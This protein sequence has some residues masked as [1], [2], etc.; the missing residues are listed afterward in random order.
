MKPKLQRLF[1]ALA[2]LT[3]VHQA[4]AQ[5]V[6]AAGTT[7]QGIDVYNGDGTIN[8]TN[9]KAS[10]ITFAYVEATDGNSYTDPEFATYWTGMK[11]AG[12]IRGAYLFF[13]PDIPGVDQ[14]N[15]FVNVMGTLQPGDL[16]PVVDV[17][18]TDSESAANI[19]TNL[20]ECINELQALTGRVPI[21]YTYT[22]FFADY[23]GGS[24]N[25]SAY[26]LWIA[27]YGITCPTLPA[28]W[29]NWVFWQYSTTGTVS[30]I[31]TPS[32]VD[33]DEFN[34][35]MS[36]LLAFA[37]PP[38]LNIVQNGTNEVSLTWSPFAIG[39][40]LQQ[41]STL[42]TTNW[43]NVTN[44]PAVASNQEQVTLGTSTNHIFFRLC[45]P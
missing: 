8:W 4:A 31:L 17:E 6:C 14:A 20:T 41:N 19:V 16:S 39:Y 26:P 25:F 15:Y 23:V 37:N 3:G 33:L 1:I 12:V 40:V 34:G 44:T 21:I 38:S 29:T 35:S 11:A 13:E 18:V 43:V 42:G 7:L 27:N 2:V 22:A 45:H 5:E 28:G 36:D 32:S 24:T 10:G 30:G 9:V